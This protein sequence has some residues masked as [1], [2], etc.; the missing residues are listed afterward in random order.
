MPWQKIEFDHTLITSD[1]LNAFQDYVME[2]EQELDEIKATPQLVPYQEERGNQLPTAFGDT[3]T[4]TLQGVLMDREVVVGD[5]LVGT[6][7]A[8]L[9]KV[10]SSDGQYADVVGLG[11]RLGVA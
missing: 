1:F 10:T 2:L 11:E 9:A 5:V 7:Q 8:A 6:D 4:I 3:A